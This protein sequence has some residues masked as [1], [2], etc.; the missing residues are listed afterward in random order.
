[1]L[2]STALWHE[3]QSQPELTRQ[4]L[5]K[6]PSTVLAA[7]NFQSGR[8][9]ADAAL[10]SSLDATPLSGAARLSLRGD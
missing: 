7:Q 8:L 9:K 6:A 10:P 1:M 5:Q 4:S 2:L 3:H